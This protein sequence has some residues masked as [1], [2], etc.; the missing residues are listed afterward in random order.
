[1]ACLVLIGGTW[2]LRL[3]PR[4]LSPQNVAPQWT[5]STASALLTT[6]VA[7]QFPSRGGLVRR[8]RGEGGGACASLPGM[9]PGAPGTGRAYPRHTRDSPTRAG[10]SLQWHGGHWRPL[11]WVLGAPG[12]VLWAGL[13]WLHVAHPASYG[14][15]VVVASMQAPIIRC[16]T[17]TSPGGTWHVPKSGSSAV[18][19]F[20]RS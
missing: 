5:R 1:M 7:I 8:R 6:P 9:A 12:P 13:P 20:T 14:K 3:C 4:A 15:G 11:S 18:L 19:L 16:P 2:Q 17:A 10:V